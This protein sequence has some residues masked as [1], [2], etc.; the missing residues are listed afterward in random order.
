M[1]PRAQAKF[2]TLAAQ[3]ML[4]KVYANPDV[5]IFEVQGA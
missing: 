4:R 3:G 2:Q 5:T 1:S